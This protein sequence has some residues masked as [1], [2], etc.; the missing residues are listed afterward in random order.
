MF[1]DR[2]SLKRFR[3][4]FKNKGYQ[5]YIL[6]KASRKQLKGEY[7]NIRAFKDIHVAVNYFRRWNPSLKKIYENFKEE[8]Y[9]KVISVNC[10]Y[11]KGLLVNG[12]H[13]IDLLCWFFGEPINAIPFN[14]YKRE[15]M[16]HGV[17]FTLTFETRIRR[18]G[19]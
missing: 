8:K 7:E 6:R 10:V 4:N 14:T 1:P 17:S 3:T 18:N 5:G 16:D 2:L 9:G 13:M 12:S 19:Y 15:D 11:T